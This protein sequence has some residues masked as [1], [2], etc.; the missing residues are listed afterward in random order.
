MRVLTELRLLAFLFRC[1]GGADRLRRCC[2]CE[3]KFEQLQAA[4]EGVQRAREGRLIMNM[5]MSADAD[6]RSDRRERD[7]RCMMISRRRNR[8]RCPNPRGW[9]RVSGEVS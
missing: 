1:G 8:R 2:C 5:I 9:A 4:S 6:N 7:D 3:L